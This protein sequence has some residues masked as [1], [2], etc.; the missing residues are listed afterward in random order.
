LDL[1]AVR[2]VGR[3]YLAAVI[4]WMSASTNIGA[5]VVTRRVD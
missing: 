2:D 5:E 4:V 3:H 1:H